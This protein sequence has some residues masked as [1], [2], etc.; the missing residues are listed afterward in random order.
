MLLFFLIFIDLSTYSNKSNCSSMLY[1]GK[2]PGNKDHDC[3]TGEKAM[4][5]AQEMQREGEHWCLG[6]WSIKTCSEGSAEFPERPSSGH[7]RTSCWRDRS[8]LCVSRERN[9]N[10]HQP[11]FIGKTDATH[12]SCG[13]SYA[14]CLA[15]ISFTQPTFR[16]CCVSRYSNLR[17]V[18]HRGWRWLSHRKDVRT[19]WACTPRLW[20]MQSEMG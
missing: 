16:R 1:E 15:C 7:P 10:S 12:Q 19:V 11:V 3:S 5:D 2:G 13:Y 14:N 4:E 20:Q 6:L 8:R 9:V 18:C 17:N